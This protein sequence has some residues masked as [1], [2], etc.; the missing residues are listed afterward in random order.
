MVGVPLGCQWNSGHPTNLYI[1]LQG[2]LF[3]LAG[4]GE[5]G[6]AGILPD[7]PPIR[8]LRSRQCFPLHCISYKQS[9]QPGY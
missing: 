1:D 5:L 2:G 8:R 9:F 3:P 6:S 4:V 7:R